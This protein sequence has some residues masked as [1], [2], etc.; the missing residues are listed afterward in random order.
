MLTLQEPKADDCYPSHA[1]HV[2]AKK[3]GFRVYRADALPLINC[4]TSADTK[5]L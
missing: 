4:W 3:L 2:C 1:L 5:I